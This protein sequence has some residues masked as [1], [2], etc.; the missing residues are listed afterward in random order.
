MAL[1]QNVLW[2]YE[3]VYPDDWVHHTQGAIETFAAN[4]EALEADYTGP[5]SGQVMVRVEWNAA[6]QPIQPIW[7]NHIGML[8]G[9][10]GARK[11]GSAPW[12][13]GGAS[14]IEAEIVL[15]T[16]DPRRLWTGILEHRLTLFHFMVLHLKEERASFEPIATALI[17]SLRLIL[18]AAA[19]EVS[20]DG[21][22]LPPGYT[23]VSPQ[24]VIADITEPQRWSAYDGSSGIDALQAF[25]VREAPNFDWQVT[26]YI[27][28][29]AQNNLGFARFRLQRENTR[30][31]LGI[32]PL[33]ETQ[34]SPILGRL[35]LKRE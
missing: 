20:D 19:L 23:P 27:P 9:W 26:E 17:S 15:A 18:R 12:H 35:A 34:D 28:Y 3:L 4:L 2:G 11:V 21:L 25:Y 6:G 14:G 10:L 22:P 30:L 31:T 1:F 33:R 16:K 8:A 13:M 24:D 7:N 5:N 29:P 32:L